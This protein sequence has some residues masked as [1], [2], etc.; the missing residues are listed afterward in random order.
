MVNLLISS[1]CFEKAVGINRPD[2]KQGE[3]N[4]S[5]CNRIL[6]FMA[7][8][9]GVGLIFHEQAWI[10]PSSQILLVLESDYCGKRNLGFVNPVITRWSLHQSRGE[11][12]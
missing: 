8:I 12:S 11:C 5:L 6:N 3:I 1:V 2:P 10:F 4:Y 9:I 7:V